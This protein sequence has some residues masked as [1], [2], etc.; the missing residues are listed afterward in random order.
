MLRGTVPRDVRNARS[1][2]A[3][4]EAMQRNRERHD[5]GKE[6]ERSS[7]ALSVARNYQK[8]RAIINKPRKE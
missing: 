8:N 6:E 4:L 7:S 2:S 1:R 3:T 5:Y